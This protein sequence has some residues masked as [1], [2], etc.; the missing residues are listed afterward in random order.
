[1]IESP[2]SVLAPAHYDELHNGSGL[3]DETIRL[4]EFRTIDDRIKAAILLGRKEVANT[5]L[6]GIELP[7]WSIDGER[8]G[9]RF[10]PRPQD[11]LPGKKASPKYLSANGAG[12]QVSFPKMSDGAWR[13]IA[14]DTTVDLF[15]TEGEKKGAKATQE[16]FPT[17]V[18]SG[19]DCFS[20]PGRMALL[21]G[22]K[23]INWRGRRVFIVFDSDRASKQSVL[24]AESKL[25]ELLRLEGATVRV[26]ELTEGADG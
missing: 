4:N 8:I 9:S 15:V 13:Q 22:F 21:P 26:V 6:P 20:K 24:L 2:I 1:M 17:L 12:P 16:G 19:V 3:S 14:K 23:D 18:I 11:Q 25:A 7:L 10:K 5:L